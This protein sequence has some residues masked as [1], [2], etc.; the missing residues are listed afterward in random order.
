MGQMFIFVNKTTEKQS[1][2]PL[3]FNFGLTW[4]KSLE[5]FSDEEME[6]AFNFVIK[7]N[8]WNETDEIIALGEY[9]TSISR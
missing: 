2:I 5:N 3:P 4:A 1:E 7:Q 9:G 8:N 6:E